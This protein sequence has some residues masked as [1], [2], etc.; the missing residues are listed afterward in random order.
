MLTHEI[1]HHTVI[2]FRPDG[3]IAHVHESVTLSGGH[4]AT[5]AEVEQAAFAHAA[6]NGHEV[7]QLKAMHVEP[8]ALKPFMHYQV[9]PVS[10][11]LVGKPAPSTRIHSR[12]I[13]RAAGP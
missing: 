8:A 10:R 12:G 7:A 3:Q 13:G 2:L 4:V 6:R 1:A 11:K 9:D 5:A